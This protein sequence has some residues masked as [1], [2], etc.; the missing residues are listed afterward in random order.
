M[1]HKNG[2]AAQTALAAIAAAAIA[3]CEIFV[4]LA[5]GEDLAC[6]SDQACPSG[7]ICVDQRCRRPGTC[8]LDQDCAYMHG[9]CRNGAC[10]AMPD[11]G[12][13]DA[14][15]DSRLSDGAAAD[16]GH[17]DTAIPDAA[18][19]D[20]AILDSAISD[21]AILD[22][23]ISDAAIPDSAISDA[24]SPDS[25]SPDAGIP[26]DWLWPDFGGRLSLTLRN[27]TS[28]WL[29]NFPVPIR[30]DQSCLPLDALQPDRSD[31]RF[32]KEGSS[33]I[34]AHEI[35]PGE[36]DRLLVWV[37]VP[38]LAASPTVTHLT[39]YYAGTDIS[40]N[41]PTAVWSDG[42]RGVWHMAG[43]IDDTVLPDSTGFRNDA[44]MPTQH[45]VRQ[46][47]L[48]QMRRFDGEI[49]VSVEDNISLDLRPANQVTLEGWALPD[50]V[51]L[52][53]RRVIGKPGNLQLNASRDTDGL[54]QFLVWR[55]DGV[56]GRGVYA[57]VPLSTDRFTYVVGTYSA[58][59][60]ILRIYLDGT[61]CATKDIP[62][63][64]GTPDLR[65]SSE[66]L[67]LGHSFVGMLDE[68]RISAVQRSPAWIAAQYYAVGGTQFVEYGACEQIRDLP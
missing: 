54:P 14:A 24:A 21:A 61:L 7:L 2:I 50:S 49:N 34:L 17:T 10:V 60:E 4:A 22:S 56:G 23:A 39:V 16:S 32:V 59:D 36:A 46:W 1:I 58:T 40:I 27:P 48:G 57:P 15:V 3:G 43:S 63:D 9:V 26:P 37:K 52:E 68:L 67:Q 12:A 18:I 53:N 33:T 5:G 65:S 28:E 47:N 45:E 55:D 42:F 35:E 64:G 29:A 38:E 13:T 8:T 51:A 20:S 31:L 19:P 11:A 62:S 66:P 41:D 30:L 25:A 44:T 6:A